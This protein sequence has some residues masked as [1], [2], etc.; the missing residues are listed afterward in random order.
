VGVSELADRDVTLL[1]YLAGDNNLYGAS[2]NLHREFLK[3]TPP[4]RAALA[5]QC[6]LLSPENGGSASFRLFRDATRTDDEDMGPLDSSA[7][8]T[9]SDFI[10]WG[11][12]QSPSRRYIL[13]IFGHSDG[14]LCMLDDETSQ[15]DMILPEF[16]EALRLAREKSGRGLDALLFDCCWMTMVEVVYELSGLCDY[17]IGCQDEMPGHGIAV[18]PIADL[19]L[20]GDGCGLALRLQQILKILALTPLLGVKREPLFVPAFSIVQVFSILTLK[21]ILDNLALHILSLSSAEMRI[22]LALVKRTQSFGNFAYRKEP[23][24]FFIDI[25]DLLSGILLEP[26]MPYGLRKSASEG[27]MALEQMICGHLRWG[28]ETAR[29]HGLSLFL[30]TGDLEPEVL[31]RF[32]L[33]R[34]AKETSWERVFAQ[35]AAIK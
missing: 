4:E 10:N 8:S 19:I 26:L 11:I 2:K 29:S 6:D 30:P 9:L 34:W 22:F 3:I 24:T 16:R 27:M 14:L 25:Y 28:R 33:L 21:E 1:V 31:H 18:A 23:Y 7:A 12:A 17:I 20:R 13:W 5:L 15:K 32:R 35:C